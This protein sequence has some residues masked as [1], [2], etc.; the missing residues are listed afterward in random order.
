MYIA[1]PAAIAMITIATITTAK[2]LEIA[3]YNI[4]PP[5]EVFST[6]M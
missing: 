3:L 6:R 5:K 4:L 1:T 2:V